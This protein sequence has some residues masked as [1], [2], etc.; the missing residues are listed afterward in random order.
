MNKNQEYFAILEALG[1]GVITV[2]HNNRVDYINKKAI[3]IIGIEPKVKEP[4]CDFFKV[5]TKNKGEIIDRIVSEVKSFG[6]TRGLEKGAY[7]DIPIKGRRYI[8]AS[9]TRI[10]VKRAYKVVLSIR[11]VTNLIRLENEHIEQ[12]NNLE[13]INNALPLG[14][15]VLDKDQ[16]VLRVNH[17]MIHH[18]NNSNYQ[19]GAYFLGDILK[20]SNAKDGLCGTTANCVSCQFRESVLSINLEK[21]SYIRKKVKFKHI[22]FGQESY[23]DYQLELVKIKDY[24]EAQTLLILKDITE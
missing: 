10:K 8:S 5:K 6:T 17:F 2:D 4:I 3:E 22:F 7:I 20:C 21:E 16:K 19:V 1:D 23:R 24:K 15:I 11:D 18:F 13:I 12:K 9:I 14:L